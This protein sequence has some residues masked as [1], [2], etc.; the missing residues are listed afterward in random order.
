MSMAKGIMQFRFRRGHLGGR[1]NKPH[2]CW[3]AEVARVIFRRG[4]SDLYSVGQEEARADWKYTRIY[5]PQRCL[6]VLVERC[7]KDSSQGNRRSELPQTS[8]NAENIEMFSV[9]VLKNRL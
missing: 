7:R 5:N 8:R 3:S 6:R 1:L 9:A 4:F 2:V